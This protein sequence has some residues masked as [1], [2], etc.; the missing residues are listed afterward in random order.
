MTVEAPLG[1]LQADTIAAALT[2]SDLPG[3]GPVQLPDLAL[4]VPGGVDLLDEGL[5]ANFDAA[6]AAGAPV[7]PV[8]LVTAAYTQALEPSAAYLRVRTETNPDVVRV[9]IDVCAPSGS[10]L[11]TTIVTWVRQLDGSWRGAGPPIILST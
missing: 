9:A 11:S 3:V 10:A 1:R 7:A 8:R 6:L 2:G 4:V 5:A